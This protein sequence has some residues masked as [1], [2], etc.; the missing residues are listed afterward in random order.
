MTLDGLEKAVYE[1][2]YPR[3]LNK[4]YVVRYADDFVILAESKELLEN[5]V[6]PAIEQFLNIRGLVLS[7]TKTRITHIDKGFDFLGFNERRYA[8]KLL[9]KPAKASIKCFMQE[10]REVIRMNIASTTDELLRQL[11]TKIKG[12]GNYYRHVV[13]KRIFSKVDDGIYIALKWWIARRHPN[14]NGSWR[15]KKYFRYEGLRNWIFS[16]K[17][18]NKLGETV[19][20]DLFKVSSIPI[21]RHIKVRRDA[22]T[23]NPVYNDYFERRLRLRRESLSVHWNHL[24]NKHSVG[25]R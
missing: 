15:T 22:T 16:T 8:G 5:K 18:R 21:I 25:I 19:N 14:K 20:F 11:N 23:Y 9:I 1:V 24:K 12:W 10:I 2:A 4:I 7:E 17:I 3:Y 13:L 6:K